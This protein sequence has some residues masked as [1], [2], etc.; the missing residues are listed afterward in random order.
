MHVHIRRC[1][2]HRLD[3]VQI[4]LP[5]IVG[6]NAPLQTH[7]SGTQRRR[8]LNPPVELRA[9]EVI[10]SATRSHLTPPF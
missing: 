5:C 3:N 6:V 7:L 4:G 9:V 1:R 10:G 8:L 2:L